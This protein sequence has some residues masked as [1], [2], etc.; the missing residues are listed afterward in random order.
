[1]D[2]VPRKAETVVD[3]DDSL[4]G[5]RHRGPIRTGEIYRLPSVD[6]SSFGDLAGGDIG[7]VRSE[8]LSR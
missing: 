7:I 6:T 4:R 1:M 3:R 8:L 2:G 5:K